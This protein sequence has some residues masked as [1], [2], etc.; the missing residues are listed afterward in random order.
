MKSRQNIV[1]STYCSS[2]LQ[3]GVSL[4]TCWLCLCLAEVF[5]LLLLSPFLCVFFW[6]LSTCKGH[7]LFFFSFFILLSTSAAAVLQ[8]RTQILEAFDK[9]TIQTRAAYIALEHEWMHLE[10]L[11]YMLAQEQRRSFESSPPP[12]NGHVSHEKNNGG[13]STD[14][15][16]RS[17][18]S[19]AP[20]AN[21]DMSHGKKNGNASADSSSAAEASQHGNGREMSH[22]NGHANDVK[23][24]VS[25]GNNGNNGNDSGAGSVVVSASNGNGAIN[26]HHGVPHGTNG[27]MHLNGDHVARP[28]STLTIPA[29]DVTLG[30]DT[31]PTKNFVWDNEGPK[32]SPQHVSS[33]Q[34]AAGPVS[35][36]EF[37]HF[38]V[39]CNGYEE[40]QYWTAADMSCLKKRKQLCP[41]T[42]TLQVALQI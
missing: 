12:A 23:G 18:E 3:G 28:V 41:A 17:F 4:T 31:D 14:S 34:M 2:P 19:S 11:A 13:V 27:H 42:W 32:Q 10:T 35:N 1:A 25:N 39:E 16:R 8:V 30:T 37:Y 36:A 15:S 40:E 26:D 22:S 38:A 21:G 9:G 7:L 6:L 29:G 5:L 33:F 24:M 20:T